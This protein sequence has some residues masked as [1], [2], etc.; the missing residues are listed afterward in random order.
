MNPTA[1]LSDEHRVIEVVLTAVE[2]LAE[3]A[4][5]EGRLDRESAE[6]AV[7]FI[8]SFADKCHH[9][10]EENHLFAAL[11]ENGMTKEGGPV[12]QMLYEHDQGRQFV[13]GMAGNIEAASGGD[14]TAVRAFAHNAGGYVELLRA[15]IQKEDRVLFPMADRILSGD[16]QNRL[17]EAFGHVESHHMGEGTHAKYLKLA[18]ALA[19]KYGVPHKI[20]V[21]T[22]CGC[23]H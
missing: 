1:I 4:L 16:E 5:R 22:S 7:D 11:I 17:L 23:H 14:A 18:V 2:R 10:K 9:G 13:A 20:E 19:D 6:K 15:H 12:G 8:R 21:K 3:E